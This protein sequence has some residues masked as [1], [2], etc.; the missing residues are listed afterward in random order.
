MHWQ[1]T[2]LKVGRSLR[3][4]T[5][6]EE[7]PLWGD[8]LQSESLHWL[9]NKAR[10][11]SRL[12]AIWIRRI[13]NTY[14]IF[15]CSLLPMSS[16]FFLRIS[17]SIIAHFWVVYT[18]TWQ[19]YLC[20]HMLE[21]VQSHFFVHYLSVRGQSCILVHSFSVRGQCYHVTVIVWNN[22]ISILSAYLITMSTYLQS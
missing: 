22:A 6:Y 17:V 5:L 18:D 13:F 16:D 14:S 2:K 15:S 1:W 19:P 20:P 7:P 3:L 12:L 8:R 9:Y 21:C 10:L 4:A 11:S